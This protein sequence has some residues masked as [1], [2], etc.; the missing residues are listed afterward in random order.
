MGFEVPG[1]SA[2]V[3]RLVRPARQPQRA[4][5]EDETSQGHEE[6]AEHLSVRHALSALSLKRAS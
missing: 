4:E 1:A 3:D 6:E 5:A 2:G